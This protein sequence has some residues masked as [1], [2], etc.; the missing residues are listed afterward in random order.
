MN[1]LVLGLALFVLAFFVQVAWWRLRRPLSSGHVLILLLVAVILLG[2]L[3]AITVASSVPTSAGYW[4]DGPLAWLQALVLALAIAAAY[5]M[6]YPAIE[7]ESPTLIIIEAIA[8]RGNAGIGI[9]EFHRVLDD[10]V[11]VKPR[12]KDL[13]NEGL[14]VLENGRYR[15]TAKGIAL[16]H[17]FVLWRRLHRA[18]LGG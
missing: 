15:P 5:A 3:T 2:W 10:A 9:D 16:V 17:I 13:L 18:G 12:L 4:P 8:Q 11:L 14:V 6:T 7:V 1:V